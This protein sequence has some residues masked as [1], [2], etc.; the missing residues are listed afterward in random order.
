MA[1]P[2]SGTISINNIRNEFGASGS[3]DMAEYYRGGARVSWNNVNVPTSGT[4]SLSNFYGAQNGYL[5][6][7]GSGGTGGFYRGYDRGLNGSTAIGSMY[8]TAWINGI[9]I[10]AIRLS[11]AVIKGSTYITFQIYMAGNHARSVFGRYYDTS[12]GN[13]YTGSSTFYGIASGYT[14]WHWT[15]PNVGQYDG[16]GAIRCYLYP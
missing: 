12:F 3:P 8:Q 14:Y 9:Q 6:Q 13:L 16:S 4:I 15:R 7:Q 5:I 1:L 10:T 11:Y 2:G